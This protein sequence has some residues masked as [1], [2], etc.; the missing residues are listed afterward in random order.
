LATTSTFSRSEPVPRLRLYSITTNQKS[1]I[2]LAQALR[3]LA[4]NLPPTPDVFSNNRPP[5][6][7]NQS[8][9]IN[10]NVRL[11][12]TAARLQFKGEELNLR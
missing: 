5:I 11:N 9:V 7:R 1:T 6:V 12:C 4:A 8:R 2:D 10:D 3:D